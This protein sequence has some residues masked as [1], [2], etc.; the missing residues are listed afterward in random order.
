[1]HVDNETPPATLKWSPTT[2]RYPIL[3]F[4]SLTDMILHCRRQFQTPHVRTE[5]RSQNGDLMLV[6]CA[7]EQPVFEALVVHSEGSRTYL[8]ELP[9]E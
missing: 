7:A 3:R 6:V 2:L 4:D 1:M 5:Y 8:V 9:V